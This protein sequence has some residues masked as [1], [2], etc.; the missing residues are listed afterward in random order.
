MA[1][2]G[3]ESTEDDKNKSDSKTD[4]LFNKFLSEVSYHLVLIE[5]ERVFQ[6]CILIF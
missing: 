4:K 2:S 6:Y 3:K 5:C 1:D